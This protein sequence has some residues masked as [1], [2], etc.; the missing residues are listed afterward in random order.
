MAKE[1]MADC[2]CPCFF[3]TKFTAAKKER[4]YILGFEEPAVAFESNPDDCEN[5]R[6]RD[7]YRF[8]G[9]V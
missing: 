7:A 2:G 6:I 1:A 8:D 9:N 3:D 5:D 4:H